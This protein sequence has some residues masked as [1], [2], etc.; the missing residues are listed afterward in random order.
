MTPAGWVRAVVAAV[1]LFL[2]YY[3]LVWELAALAALLMRGGGE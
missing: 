3:A 1:L 2:G